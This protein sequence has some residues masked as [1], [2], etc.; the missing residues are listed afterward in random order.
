MPGI[1]KNIWKPSWKMVA[2]LFQII[3]VNPIIRLFAT[4]RRAWIFA[5][6]LKGATANA[7]LYTLVETAHAV[8]LNVYEI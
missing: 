4:A 1:R 7:V 5:N 6:T 8:D 2:C 3:F